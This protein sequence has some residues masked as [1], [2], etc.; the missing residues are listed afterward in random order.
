MTAFNGFVVSGTIHDAL[1]DNG[2]LQCASCHDVHFK[3]SLPHSLNIPKSG[4]QIC[5]TCHA[6]G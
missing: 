4:D 5:T 1:L 3:F 6:K 2:Q